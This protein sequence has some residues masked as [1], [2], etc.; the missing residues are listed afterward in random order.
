MARRVLWLAALALAA[1]LPGAA[2]AQTSV[3]QLV[4]QQGPWTSVGAPENRVVSA[5]GPLLVTCSRGEE[6][7]ADSA[8]LYQTINEVHLFGSVDYQDPTRALT[9]DRAIYNGQTGRLYATGNVVFTDKNRGSTLRGPD[10]E[11]FRAME[12]RP[13]AQAIA[14]GRPHLTVVPRPREGGDRNRRRDPLEVDGDRITSVGER[15]VTAEGNVVIVS[16]DSRSTAAEAFYDADAERTELRRNAFV[17]GKDYDLRADFIES[18]LADGALQKVLART[19]A[20]LESERLNLSGPQL[21]LFFE[22]ELLQRVI[23]GQ[24]QGKAPGRSLALGKGLRIEADSLEAISPEQKLRQV[25]AIGNARGEQWDT[26]AART[27]SVATPSTAD[28]A[29]DTATVRAV[30]NPSGASDPRTTPPAAVEEKDLLLADTILAFFREAGAAADSAGADSTGSAAGPPVLGRPAQGDSLRAAPAAGDTAGRD[31][32]DTVLDRLLAIGNA[33]SVYRVQN[34]STRA[35]I[36]KPAINYLAGDRIDLTFQKG[37]VDV[38]NVNGL[39][40]GIYLDPQTPAEAAADSAGADSAAAARGGAGAAGTGSS[41]PPTN[42]GG[43]PRPQT[44]APAGRPRDL[45]L[46]PQR[47][48]AGG[49]P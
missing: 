47:P 13:E 49:R 37:E 16:K 44:P 38:A 17:D 46:Q 20:K 18:Q 23:S 26:L 29:G 34:D 14:V 2:A 12:G 28:P 5:S 4:S 6:L 45:P 21:Q 27:P 10:L 15:Y 31:T 7:R 1:A 33:R 35:G 41:R 3:C 24:E 8:V 40:R 48:T 39:K 11:Y 30:S 19:D 9:S 32:A 36:R 43:A 22:R 25:T 42:S